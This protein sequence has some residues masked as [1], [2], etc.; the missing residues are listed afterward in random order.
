MNKAILLILGATL[1]SGCITFDAGPETRDLP[2]GEIND[3]DEQATDVDAGES[4]APPMGDNIPPEV[5]AGLPLDLPQ[6]FLTG[7][8]YGQACDDESP[9]RDGLVCEQDIC[10]AEGATEEGDFCLLSIECADGQCVNSRCQAWGDGEAGDECLSSAECGEGL[11][12]GIVGLHA[13]CIEEGELGMGA[14]CAS[15]NDCLSG[16]A[17]V[18]LGNADVPTCAPVA[19]APPAV[20]STWQGV[21]C[22]DPSDDRVRAFFEIPGAPDAD[23]LDFFRLPFPNDIRTDDR[24]R[25]DVSDFPTPGLNPIVGVDPIKPYVDAVDGTEGWGTNSTVTFRFSGP[26]D[27]G[28]FR[29][30]DRIQWVDITDPEDP[31]KAGISYRTFTG[32]TN[33]VCHNVLSVRRFNG[34]PMEPGHTYAV[35]LNTA[36]RSDSGLAIDRAE[37]FES[38]LSNSEPS[39][40]VLADAHAKFAPFREY[41]SAQNIDPD[42][43]LVATVITVGPVRDTMTELAAAVYDTD[44]PTASDWTLCDGDTPSPCPQAEGTRACGQNDAYDEYQALVELPIFQ[45]GEPPYFEE[46]GDIQTSEPVR[47]EEVCMALSIPKGANMPDSGWPLVVFTHGTGGSYRSHLNNTSVA[48][49]LASADTPDGRV[50]FA[51]LGYDQVQHGPRRGDSQESPENLFF[52]FL[53]P[54]A[55]QGNPLQGAADVISMG[56]FA[57]DLDIGANVSGGDAIAVDP[58]RVV[59]FGHSQG[60]MHGSLGL[61][62]SSEYKAAVLSG[63][64]VSLMHALL[65]KTEPVNIK[66]VVPLVINDGVSIDITTGTVVGE[67]P[68]EDHNPVLSLIQHHIDPADPL[69]FG[70][71]IAREP[72]DG[73][74]PKHVF[75][76]YGDGD[77]YSPP[78]TMEIYAR[79]SQMVLVEPD[80]SFDAEP[81][82]TPSSEFPLLASFGLDDVEYTL[83]MR[84]YGP[85]DGSDGHFVVFDVPAAND[86]ALRFLGMAASGLTP[87]IGE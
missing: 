12:C 4:P 14:E 28:S 23:E 1:A 8:T 2:P 80:S 22:E 60:S 54:D 65:T 76:T 26:I 84:Q 18:L 16:M 27:L 21:E 43:V 58:E 64:G 46:G 59:F 39:N 83:G 42:D 47:T 25:V 30:E 19:G 66:A 53:N 78:L 70:K 79:A 85:P 40:S 68:D 75:A 77:S 87:Q 50:A 35:W 62:Y 36:G 24:G 41:L 52:N 20:P 32:R 48:E 9:C 61:P 55:S 74:L 17:C 6:G 45:R 82:S 5:V 49:N 33:Y 51:V 63:N 7:R 73:M 11:R 71:Q 31:V 34:R 69:N 3:L 57:A 44:V 10:I 38:M 86:D 15:S 29:D 67:L 72:V 37:N 13:Q 81:F 56:R